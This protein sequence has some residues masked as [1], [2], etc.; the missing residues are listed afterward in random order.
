M[1]KKGERLLPNFGGYWEEYEL[2]TEAFVPEKALPDSLKK[3]ARK[4]KTKPN[5]D[6]MNFGLTLYGILPLHI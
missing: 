6:Y 2:W 1:N 4:T 5:N 3:K